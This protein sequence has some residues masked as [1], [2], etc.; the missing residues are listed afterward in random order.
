[1][2]KS[3]EAKK[4]DKKQPMRTP[5]EKRALKRDKKKNKGK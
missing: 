2:A 5:E 3:H 1:M 4:M